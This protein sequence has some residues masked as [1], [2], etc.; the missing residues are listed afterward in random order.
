[1]VVFLS[2]FISFCCCCWKNF[3]KL[4]WNVSL[5]FVG[6][7]GN[8]ELATEFLTLVM[9]FVCETM[10][11]NKIIRWN[12]FGVI[13]SGRTPEQIFH[14]C[15]HARFNRAFS[16]TTCCRHLWISPQ[17]LAPKVKAQKMEK[18]FNWTYGTQRWHRMWGRQEK[19]IIKK[20]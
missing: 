16:Y 6:V 19:A 18:I 4:L 1:M 14:Q 10:N 13:K 11:K 17:R 15:L 9:G 7:K 20:K 12:F 2:F 8:Y 3:P 5:Y